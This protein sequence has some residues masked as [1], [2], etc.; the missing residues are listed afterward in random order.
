MNLNSNISDQKF[1]EYFRDLE[2]AVTCLEQEH[3]TH[4]TSAQ[5]VRDEMRAV[6]KKQNQ[7]RVDTDDLCIHKVLTT[8]EITISYKFL[9]LAHM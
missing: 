4:F 9:H 8:R 1:K 6:S 2:A 5:D 7:N 3:P